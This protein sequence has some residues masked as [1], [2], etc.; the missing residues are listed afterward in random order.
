MNVITGQQ[1]LSK[2]FPKQVVCAVSMCVHVWVS[3][4]IHVCRE[5]WM[6]RPMEP[7]GWRLYVCVWVQ[8]AF[9][10]F[11]LRGVSAVLFFGSVSWKPL[12]WIS[13]FN[14]AGILCLHWLQSLRLDGNIVRICCST[15]KSLRRITAQGRQVLFYWGQEKWLYT[16]NLLL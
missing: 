11:K 9:G 5:W 13:S 4:C 15:H 6:G 1:Y 7:S 3:V 16:E 14:T 10:I 2:C 12:G 8:H